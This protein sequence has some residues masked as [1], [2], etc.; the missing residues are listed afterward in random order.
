MEARDIIKQ[1]DRVSGVSCEGK[2]VRGGDLVRLRD[3]QEE[4][5]AVKVI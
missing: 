4:E 1:T 3:R 2:E 5:V